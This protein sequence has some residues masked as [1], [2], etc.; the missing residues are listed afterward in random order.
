M[1]TTVTRF[2]RVDVLVN[3]VGVNVRGAADEVAVADFERSLAVNVTGTWLACRA[4]ARPMR[5]AGYGRIV[6]LASALGVAG[7]AE[8]SASAASKPQW[9][10]SPGPAARPAPA[11]PSTRLAPGPFRTPLNEGVAESPRVQEFLDHEIPLH[12]WGRLDEIGPRPCSCARRGPRTPPAPSCRSTVGGWPTNRALRSAATRYRSRDGPR[13]RPRPSRLH[14]RPAGAHRGR[15]RG[16]RRP[17]RAGRAAHAPRAQRPPRRAH[18]RPG[19]AQAGGPAGRALLQAAGRLQPDLPA[20]PRGAGPR[21]GVRQRRQPRPGR[22]LQLPPPRRARAHLRAPHDAPAE[23]RAHHRL[24]RRPRHP[25]RHRR[26]LRRRQRGRAGRRRPPA[27]VLVPPF[28]HPRTIAGQ[29]TVA[30]EVVRQ[31]GRPRR[32]GRPGAAAAV[33]W[34]GV[35]TWLRPATRRRASSV[36]SPPARPA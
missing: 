20:V 2:G 32:A 6:N 5:A 29:G 4:A 23:A 3:S 11:S 22:G 9:C 16:G 21:R 17:A 36:S 34:P 27:A 30:V 13:Y 15:R 35:A 25:H 1:N 19:V 10:R 8:R 12:R 28:D 24:R 26:H 18:R 14:R 31:L 7:A 33:C